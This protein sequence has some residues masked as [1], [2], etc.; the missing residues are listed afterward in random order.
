[1]LTEQVNTLIVGARHPGLAMS[2]LGNAGVP[3]LVL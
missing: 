2:E 3:H 1:M